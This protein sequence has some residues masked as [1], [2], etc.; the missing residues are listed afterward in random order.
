MIDFYIRIS[1]DKKIISAK[2]FIVLG[3][4]INEI[5]KMTLALRKND[6]TD[7]E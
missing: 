4:F 7:D 5:K 3:K 6:N 2:Q 1:F